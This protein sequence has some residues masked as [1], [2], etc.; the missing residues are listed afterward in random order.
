MIK[1]TLIINDYML[2]LRDL[3][4]QLESNG[5]TLSKEDNVLYLIARF[6]HNYEGFVSTIYRRLQTKSI[7]LADVTTLLLGHESL[8]ESYND[9]LDEFFPT[10][11]VAQQL[12]GQNVNVDN[13]SKRCLR[14]ALTHNKTNR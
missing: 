13:T 11:N 9:Y 6:D 8:L 7:S 3:V 2:K 5:Y 14:V 4:G 12:K 1:G 10:T